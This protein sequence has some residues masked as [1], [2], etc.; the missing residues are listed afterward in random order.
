[1]FYFFIHCIQTCE[2]P[3]SSVTKTDKPVP[4]LLG[5]L[6][7]QVVNMHVGLHL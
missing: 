2:E 6:P 3:L 7:D 4:S 5:V 1:M